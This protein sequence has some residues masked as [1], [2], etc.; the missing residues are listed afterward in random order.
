MRKIRILSVIIFALS[1]GTFTFFKFTDKKTTDT[2][3]PIIQMEP[4]SIEVPSGA[5]AEELLAGVTATDKKDGDVTASLVIERMTN[6]TE[7]GRRTITIAAFDSDNNVTKTTREIVYSDYTAPSF[8]LS[9]P[10]YFPEN[11]ASSFAEKLTA[12]DVLDGDLTEKIKMSAVDI[13]Q[14]DVAGDYQVIF[15][16]SNSAGDTAQLPVTVTIYDPSEKPMLPDIIL[17]EYLIHVKKGES[18][19]PWSYIDEV[20]Y[21]GTVYKPAA[22]SSGGNVL[23]E[24]MSSLADVDTYG[25]NDGRKYLTNI[26]ITNSVDVNTPGTYE[27]TYRVTSD[28][29]EEEETGTMRLIVVVD[30]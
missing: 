17:S 12:S 21:R 13:L 7:R 6:F 10:L 22:G 30:E 24:E 16:V 15:T 27:I 19:D 29:T 1:A 8:Q 2:D 5:G 23:A 20:N 4:E 26:D 18:V 3:G 9:E 11:N 28:E 25:E 14:F